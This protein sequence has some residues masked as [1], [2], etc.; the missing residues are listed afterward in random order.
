VDDTPLLRIEGLTKR[1][2]GAI[3]LDDLSIGRNA[4]AGP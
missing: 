4:I 1:Y 3:A 2:P